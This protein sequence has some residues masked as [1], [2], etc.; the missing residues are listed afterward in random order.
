MDLCPIRTRRISTRSNHS[1]SRNI[2]AYNRFSVGLFSVSVSSRTI[3]FYQ[4]TAMDM[5]NLTG[6]G[7]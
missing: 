1:V 7:T 3:Y 4:L 5:I 2:L 6:G